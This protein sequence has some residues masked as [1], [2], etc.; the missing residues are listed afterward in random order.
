MTLGQGDLGYWLLD[1]QEKQL[2]SLRTQQYKHPSTSVSR[3]QFKN[4][5]L[6]NTPQECSVW[7]VAQMIVYWEANNCW[8]I[9]LQRQQQ[10]QMAGWFPSRYNAQY[11]AVSWE[12]CKIAGANEE[13]KNVCG[14]QGINCYICLSLCVCVCVYTLPASGKIQW[15]H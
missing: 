11:C 9:P 1:Q 8:E 10:E 14:N 15:A 3:I 13:E 7:S 5:I 4:K 6:W 12:R 2:A